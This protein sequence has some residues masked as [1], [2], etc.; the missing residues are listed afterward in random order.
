M[1]SGN[2]LRVLGLFGVSLR[3]QLIVGLEEI[4]DVSANK[5]VRLKFTCKVD[6]TNNYLLAIT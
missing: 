3:L 1:D 5:L 2:V 4:E 6:K